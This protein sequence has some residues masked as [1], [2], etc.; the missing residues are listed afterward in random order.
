MGASEKKGRYVG[1]DR[2]DKGLVDFIT[3]EIGRMGSV[4]TASFV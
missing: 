4:A 2:A 3:S 1:E